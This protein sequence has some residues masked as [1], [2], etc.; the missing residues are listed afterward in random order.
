MKNIKTHQ[1]YTLVELM[2]SV[3]IFAL[4][5]LLATSAYFS[6]LSYTRQAR[7]TSVVMTNLSAGLDLMARS[8]RT[9][10]SYNCGAGGDCT[11]TPGN[12]FTFTEADGTVTTYSLLQFTTG[13]AIGVCT[14]AVPASS[15]GQVSNDVPIN[16]TVITDPQVDISKLSFYVRGTASGDGLQPTVTIVVQ[17]DTIVPH[18]QPV[19]FS[20]Q[21]SATQRLLDL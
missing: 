13:G 7:A 19:S 14:N 16:A 1:G 5:M 6:L 9:G 4:I 10:N 17:G 3:G 21:S 12:Y 11:V 8:I 20:V 18:G 15:C 2:V